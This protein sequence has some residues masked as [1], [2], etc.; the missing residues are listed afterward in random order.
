M[1]TN[2]LLDALA[3]EAEFQHAHGPEMRIACI[4]LKE[5]IKVCKREMAREQKP[6]HPQPAEHRH[7]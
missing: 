6:K 3:R 2:Q 1:I 5:M 7:D 4:V